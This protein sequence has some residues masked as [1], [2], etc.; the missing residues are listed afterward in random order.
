MNLWIHQNLS[1]IKVSMS[2]FNIQESQEKARRRLKAIPRVSGRQPRSDRGSSRVDRRVLDWL[3]EATNGYDRPAMSDVLARVGDRCRI[4][5][6]APP[7]RATAYKLM[8]TLPTPVYRLDELPLAVR[9]ALYN[10]APES[11]V[12]AHQVAFYCFNYGD[13]AAI[14]FASGLPWRALYQARLLPGHRDKSRSL[15]DAVAQARGL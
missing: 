1:I 7:S 9:N 2:M 11:N 3:A 6:I 4:A 10:L 14:S 13:L 12:P 8:A 15:L 5:G